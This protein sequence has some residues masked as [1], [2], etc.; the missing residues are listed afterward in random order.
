MVLV[1]NFVFGWEVLSI[2]MKTFLYSSVGKRQQSL[3]NTN[4]RSSEMR[5]Y[6]MCKM[7]VITSLLEMILGML[8]RACGRLEPHNHNKKLYCVKCFTPLD[9]IEKYDLWCKTCLMDVMNTRRCWK[10]VSSH[11]HKTKIMQL[12]HKLKSIRQGI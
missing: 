5:K 6:E 2:S 7:F 3:S 11:R 9:N 1:T 8:C 12:S 10:A 4:N